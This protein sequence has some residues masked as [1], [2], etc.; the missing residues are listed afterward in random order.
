MS[1]M[2]ARYEAKRAHIKIRRS[3]RLLFV[4]TTADPPPSDLPDLS[5]NSPLRM[6]VR[7]LKA[8]ATK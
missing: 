7:G 8:R 6:E 5:V 1:A 4:S 3:G 2:E